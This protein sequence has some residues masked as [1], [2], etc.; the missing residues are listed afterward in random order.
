MWGGS[1]DSRDR[2]RTLRAR[3]LVFIAFCG[4]HELLSSDG[5]FLLPTKQRPNQSDSTLKQIAIWDC[6]V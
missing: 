4:L 5:L 3:E 1:G 2:T 6:G